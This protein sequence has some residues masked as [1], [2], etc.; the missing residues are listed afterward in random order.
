MRQ[1]LPAVLPRGT[2]CAGLLLASFLLLGATAALGAPSVEPIREPALGP[3]WND[4]ERFSEGLLD[5]FGMLRRGEASLESGRHDVVSVRAYGSTRLVIRTVVPNRIGFPVTIPPNGVLRIALAVLPEFAAVDIIDKTVPVRFA[6]TLESTD[7]APV[8]LFERVVD[9][10]DRPNDRRWHAVRIDL[11]AYAGVQGTL[12]LQQEV[13]GKPGTNEGAI[14]AWSRPALFDQVEQRSRPNLLLITIDALRADHLSCYGYARKTSPRLDEL[15]RAGIRYDRALTNAPMT[16][17]SVPQIMTSRYFPDK[18]QPT[19]ATLLFAAG[20]PTTRAIVQ[21]PFL[22]L[23]L[24]G[25]RK[26]FDTMLSGELDADDIT[27]AAVRWLDQQRGDRFA[28]YL[29]Y[30]DTHTP[31]RVP[32]RRAGLFV[33]P[34]YG[35]PIGL[36]FRD[37]DGARAGR[38]V[39]DDRRRIVDLYDGTIH[40][41][42]AAI[43]RL[44]DA[45]EARGVLD[46]TLVVITA[47]HG[48]EFW[49][50]GTFFHGQS[51]YNEQLHVPLIMR[52]PAGAAAGTVVEHAVRA[53]D[54]LPTI[55]EVMRLPPLEGAAGR[56]LLGPTGN[57]AGGPD[58]EV[59]A[60]AVNLQFPQRFA[61]RA[62]NHKLIV[63]VETGA[64]ELYDLVRDPGERTNLVAAADRATIREQLRSRLDAYRGELRNRGLQI[65]AVATDG[66]THQIDTSI[67]ADGVPIAY[68]DRIDL[69]ADNRLTLSEDGGTLRWTGTITDVPSG[70]RFGRGAASVYQSTQ[71]LTFKILVDGALLPQDAVRLGNGEAAPSMPFTYSYPEE[72]PKLLVDSPPSLHGTD[73]PVV[74]AIWQAAGGSA[75]EAAVAVI[76]PED[77][78][79]LRALG[80][81]E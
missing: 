32:A 56:S 10:R 79:R 15:A 5:A 2:S 53:V 35:G 30:L 60:G 33:D 13:A 61:V 72:E 17:P 1:G 74:V 58:R 50:H 11:S 12:V 34:G 75:E 59:F 6:V 44:I 55:T 29:H 18:T 76:G 38:Y 73:T 20:M 69:A 7:A 65:R 9:I 62:L 51:L 40:Y 26:G 71:R 19:V 22:S 8:L 3:A 24:T 25:S 43:G 66:R 28:L 45:L 42:D 54:I 77:R 36:R 49:D 57:P 52:L 23:W 48:E 27:R 67:E 64:E 14:V 47:D 78:E 39:G 68:P 46:S 70:I 21:N 63:S 41:V 81:V 31:Y 37:A 80:Y 16:I 4:S